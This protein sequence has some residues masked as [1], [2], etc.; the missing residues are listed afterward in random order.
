M[1]NI[2]NSFSIPIAQIFATAVL[3]AEYQGGITQDDFSFSLFPTHFSGMVEGKW[4]AQGN[5]AKNPIK[6]VHDTVR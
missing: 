5:H 4:K 3:W 6:H 2:C 1:S